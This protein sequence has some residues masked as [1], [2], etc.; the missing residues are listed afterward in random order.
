M[1]PRK[2]N[3]RFVLQKC[4]VCGNRFP[5]IYMFNENTIAPFGFACPH[6]HEGSTF[7]PVDGQPTFREWYEEQLRLRALLVSH[8]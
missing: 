4:D 7:T 3:Y 8:A 1:H 6:P 5:V 2:E